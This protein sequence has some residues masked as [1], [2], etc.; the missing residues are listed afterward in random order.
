MKTYQTYYPFDRLALVVDE[1][2]QRV[3][4]LVWLTSRWGVYSYSGNKW[5]EEIIKQFLTKGRL[6][7]HLDS[8]N[9]WEILHKFQELTGSATLNDFKDYQVTYE[10]EYHELFDLSL[11]EDGLRSAYEISRWVNEFNEPS[12]VEIAGETCDRSKY[13]GHYV[14]EI[15]EP[16]EQ[17]VAYEAEILRRRRV[18]TEEGVREKLSW[19]EGFPVLNHY[20]IDVF[21]HCEDRHKLQE[22][23]QDYEDEWPY[24]TRNSDF[25]S[26]LYA[27][28]QNSG[29]SSF[30]HL[31]SVS[32][33]TPATCSVGTVVAQDNT[34]GIFTQARISTLASG[35]CSI[36]WSFA[37]TADRAATSTT[38]NFT[39]R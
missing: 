17:R 12:P 24:R 28:G 31:L 10:F 38:M 8:K 15:V 25:G 11:D 32:S 13:Y 23:G 36:L 21:N 39:I 30:G 18:A 35:N 33:S 5:N 26:T 4:Q 34:G 7:A 1:N 22:I 6:Y 20:A 14:A 9:F 27:N 3:L 16:E 29:L 19:I 2:D 37:G